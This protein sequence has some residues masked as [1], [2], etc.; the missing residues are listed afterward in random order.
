MPQQTPQ[1]D[2]ATLAALRT[3]LHEERERLRALAG[4][5]YDSSDSASVGV[6]DPITTDA[7]DFGDQALD[8]T[9]EDTQ[10][11]L[12]AHDRALLRQVERALARMD[13][14][15]YGLSEVSGKPIAIERLQALP[16]ATTNVED[17]PEGGR[18]VDTSPTY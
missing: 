7:E 13:A 10:M 11:A 5:A 16:W 18:I 4:A 17:S 1:I 8:I 14:G 6:H 3:R 9:T 15:S 12:A 2:Q